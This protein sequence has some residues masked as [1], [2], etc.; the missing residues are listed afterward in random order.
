MA[1]RHKINEDFIRKRK[2]REGGDG[3]RLKEQKEVK[4]YT[5]SDKFSHPLFL[6]EIVCEIKNSFPIFRVNDA[7]WSLS[8]LNSTQVSEIH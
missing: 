8:T 6:N 2:R 1:K 3:V 5:K 4:S 7:E